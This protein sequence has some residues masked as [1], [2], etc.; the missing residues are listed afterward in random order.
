MLLGY[1]VEYHRVGRNKRSVTMVTV[2]ASSLSVDIVELV[3]F[4][5]YRIIVSGFTSKG[6]GNQSEITCWTSEDG[7]R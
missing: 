6:D 3:K 7:K 5:E 4:S 1:H 2:N